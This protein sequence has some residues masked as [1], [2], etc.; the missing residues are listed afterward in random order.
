M[1]RL[2]IVKHIVKDHV[3]IAFAQ[4]PILTFL[5]NKNLEKG[6]LKELTFQNK[7]IIFDSRIFLG[8]NLKNLQTYLYIITLWG[9]YPPVDL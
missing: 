1:I 7:E 9:L 2:N 8:P 3:L 5:A 6:E 4:S